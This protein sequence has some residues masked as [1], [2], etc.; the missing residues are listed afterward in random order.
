LRTRWLLGTS[1]VAALGPATSAGA[2]ISRIAATI[3]IISRLVRIGVVIGAI[4]V[5]IVVGILVRSAR[6]E[7]AAVVTVALGV[8]PGALVI[9]T[10][11]KVVFRHV[12]GLGFRR[13]R[14]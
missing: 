6:A 2:C 5:A 8:C 9:V 14:I 7:V 10:V 11:S 13:R 12:C 3:V 1:A 4:T